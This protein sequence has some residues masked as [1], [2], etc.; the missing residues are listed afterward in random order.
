V[1]Q[2]NLHKLKLKFLRIEPVQ[3]FLRVERTRDVCRHGAGQVNE[4]ESRQA[5]EID[6]VAYTRIVDEY[7]V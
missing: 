2:K 6:A 4:S 1:A 3:L 7:I 5:T